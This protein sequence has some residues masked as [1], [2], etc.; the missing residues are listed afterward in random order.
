MVN[1]NHF[2]EK[3]LE[4]IN[5]AEAPETSA[6]HVPTTSAEIPREQ[7]TIYTGIKILGQWKAF[8]ERRFL[9][10]RL[11]MMVPAEFTKMDEEIARVKYPMEQRPEMILTDST[12]TSNILISYIVQKVK[13]SEIELVRDKM[14]RILC[15]VNPGINPQGIGKETIS[16][17][18][19]AFTAF[20][21]PTIDSKLYNLMFFLEL[22]ENV[23]MI[24]INFLAN[25]VKY[26]KAPAY[27]MMR[28]IKVSETGKEQRENG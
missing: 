7:Q 28:S 16:G 19:V 3:I 13:D 6:A 23:V 15:R 24:S 20:T 10:N 11:A 18:T 17:K 27:E 9:D 4:L 2:D 25:S 21:N 14:F 22:D 12:G 26:W 1:D 8:E 5:E